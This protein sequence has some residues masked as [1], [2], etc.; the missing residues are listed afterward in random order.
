MMNDKVKSVVDN[1]TKGMPVY[2]IENCA[3]ATKR[4]VE[5]HKT[6]KLVYA[7]L[8]DLDRKLKPVVAS[9]AEQE[10][11]HAALQTEL[12]RRIGK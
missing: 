12:L 8:A 11:F 6:D 7:V 9:F 3:M 10:A 2:L 5:Q 4:I 1:I